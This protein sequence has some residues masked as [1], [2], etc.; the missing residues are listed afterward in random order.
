[1]K[2]RIKMSKNIKVSWEVHGGGTF[3]VS[4][5]EIEGMTEEEIEEYIYEGAELKVVEQSEYAI[6]VRRVG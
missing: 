3:E 6:S 1:M 5:V 4:P 2:R